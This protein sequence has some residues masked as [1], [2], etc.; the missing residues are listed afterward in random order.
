MSGRAKQ[1][2]KDFDF[3]VSGAKN[4]RAFAGREVAATSSP[5]SSKPIEGA[6]PEISQTP[7]APSFPSDSSVLSHY[8]D[9]LSQQ[10]PTSSI[11][12]PPTADAPNTFQPPATEL[13]VHL[14]GPYAYPDIGEMNRR[15]DHD[16][17]PEG[18][19][20]NNEAHQR[21]RDRLPPDGM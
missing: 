17:A 16:F 18:F 15:R 4:W 10:P 21:A 19:T 6:Q 3:E 5:S 14:E 1:K 8:F 2:A 7:P 20:F 11:D 12:P 9:T 13:E